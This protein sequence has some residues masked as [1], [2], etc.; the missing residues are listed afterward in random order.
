ML[1][2]PAVSMT[3]SDIPLSKMWQHQPFNWFQ[4]RLSV[5]NSVSWYLMT[6]MNSS[7]VCINQSCW[8]LIIFWKRIKIF[9][10]YPTSFNSSKHHQKD[11]NS[12]EPFLT[13][14]CLLKI[15]ISFLPFNRISLDTICKPLTISPCPLN[16]SHCG[17][18][19][20]LIT[21]SLTFCSNSFKTFSTPTLNSLNSQKHLECVHSASPLMKKFLTSHGSV[22]Y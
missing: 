5:I 21:N 9:P 15:S 7:R 4:K 2:P 10:K 11:Q 17:I 22:R 12:P 13:Q 1:F 20:P 18:F 8:S 19:M 6:C 3:T 14:H 16:H